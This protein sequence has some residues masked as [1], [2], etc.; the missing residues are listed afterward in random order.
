VEHAGRLVCDVETD[1]VE[2]G[3]G[4]HGKPESPHRA[5]D[6]LDRHALLEQMA[7]LVHVGREKAVHPE[8]GG[9]AY[10]DD[11]LSHRPAEGDR[12]HGYPGRG[13]LRDDDLE[14]RHLLDG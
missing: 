1:L 7:R 9:I 5:V 12:R 8:P 11:R 14:E 13:S 2:Q 3:D 4:T 10:D 6:R